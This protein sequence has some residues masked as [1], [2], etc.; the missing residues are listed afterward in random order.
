VIGQIANPDTLNGPNSASAEA[1]QI[2]SVITQTLYTLSPANGGRTLV[3]ELAT[4]Y[5]LS[6]HNRTWTFHLRHDVRF[7]TGRP[8]TSADVKFSLLNAEKGTAQ[9]AVDAAISG[10]AAPGRY[11]VAIT[12][13][14]PDAALLSTVSYYSNGIIPINFGGRT[15]KAFWDAPIGTGPFKLQSWDYGVSLTL[16]KNRY[17][18]QPGLPHLASVVFKP[19]ASDASRVAGLKAGSLD[20]I[21]SPPLSQ[22][23][24]LKNNPTVR[25]LEVPGAQDDS[26]YI[27]AGAKGPLTN[28]KVRE[29]LSLAINRQQ[30]AQALLF[31]AG[32]AAS[33]PVPLNEPL[34]GPRPPISSVDL[35]RAR[36][37]LASTPYV[38]GFSMNLL[39]A[40]G[41]SLATSVG[42]VLQQEF[43][44]LGVRLT[45]SPTDQSEA[46]TDLQKGSYQAI[47][48]PDTAGQIDPDLEAMDTPQNEPAQLKASLN[49]PE[50]AK[51]ALQ[52]EQTF[53]P[54]AREA[55]YQRFLALY[56]QPYDPIPVI[57][58]PELVAV[59][60]RVNGFL[61]IQGI[62]DLT[63][64]SVTGG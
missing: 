3:P 2:L 33:A 26:L 34:F 47:F 43:A 5:T 28:Y 11:D 23:P 61:F 53:N 16:T 14:R 6:N 1:A 44:P 37:L 50:M 32:L 38:H 17:Y 62:Y 42:Q 31:G 48:V 49:F 19:V 27:N 59:S 30:I 54:T 24:Q 56:I 60:K 20:A 63:N 51:L 58:E 40:S 52:A 22:V 15:S 21:E 9:G 8:L 13:R 36:Q 64:A 12:T 35:A 57:Y 39:T 45:V 7:S 46:I 41:N 25:I 4:S 10:V 29:A 18:W 55:L